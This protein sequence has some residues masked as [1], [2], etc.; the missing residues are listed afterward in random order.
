MKETAFN[1]AHNL[2]KVQT[3]IDVLHSVD[4]D[5]VQELVAGLRVKAKKLHQI[6]EIDEE[7]QEVVSIPINGRVNEYITNYEADEHSGEH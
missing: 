7:E 5:G 1:N 6:V 3:A 4:D 2:I